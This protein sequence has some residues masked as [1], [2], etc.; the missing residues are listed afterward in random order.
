MTSPGC[1]ETIILLL[2]EQK[3]CR[4]LVKP[5][6]G[7][8]ETVA[9][10]PPLEAQIRKIISEGEGSHPFIYMKRFI[11]IIFTYQ[12]APIYIFFLPLPIF[13][14]FCGA[15]FTSQVATPVACLPISGGRNS[16]SASIS[17]LC[18]IVKFRGRYCKVRA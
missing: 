18:I 15:H 17:G 9:A 6:E 16:P 4:W 7:F 12:R 11:I 10:S 14:H 8:S 2:P 1:I 3:S 5:F 13:L